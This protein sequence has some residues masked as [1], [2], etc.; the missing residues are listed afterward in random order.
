M[1]RAED[2]MVNMGNEL[3]HWARRLSF[4]GLLPFVGGVLLVRLV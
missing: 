4:A 2:L 3:P 1:R